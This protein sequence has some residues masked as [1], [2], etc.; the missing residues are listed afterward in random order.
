MISINLLL[1]VTVHL[2]RILGHI[3]LLPV[4]LC[5]H[6]VVPVPVP[7]FLLA[8]QGA[9]PRHQAPSTGG[10]LQLPE[11]D[12]TQPTIITVILVS[13]V[14]EHIRILWDQEYVSIVEKI[15]MIVIGE[16]PS[17]DAFKLL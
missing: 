4:S 13:V 6:A 17:K 2:F 15:G 16:I 1:P 8:A 14:T 9:V 7:I 3:L 10:L 12:S 5:L 11:S